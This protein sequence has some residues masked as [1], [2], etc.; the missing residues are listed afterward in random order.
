MSTVAQ[1][2]QTSTRPTANVSAVRRATAVGLGAAAL[3]VVLGIESIVV[4]GE[5]HYRDVWWF[6]P[7]AGTIVAFAGLYV[8]QRA[9]LR[10]WGRVAFGVVVTTMVAVMAGQLGVVLDVD[11]LKVLGFP[12]GAL[13]WLA[14]MIPAGIATARAGVVR[15]R[16]GVLMALLEPLS[17][18]TGVALAPIAGLYDRGNYS[19]AVEKGVVLLLI[20]R[21]V[22]RTLCAR[23]PF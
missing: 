8:V 11:R 13:L 7:W 16:A 4:G 15:R 20:V 19:G 22:S 1:D 2:A 17:I 21:E 3:W 23:A 18:A 12:L 6:L 9:A 14:S 5:H 10:P